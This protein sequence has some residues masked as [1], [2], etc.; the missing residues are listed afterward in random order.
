MEH[1]DEFGVDLFS[2]ERRPQKLRFSIL[3][4]NELTLPDSVVDNRPTLSNLLDR[5]RQPNRSTHKSK[6]Q[7]EI[8]NLTTK[9]SEIADFLNN[10]NDNIDVIKLIIDL[11]EKLSTDV[12][13][14]L[15]HRFGILSNEYVTLWKDCIK[16]LQDLLLSVLPAEMFYIRDKFDA[17]KRERQARAFLKK[18]ITDE[19]RYKFL[20]ECKSKFDAIPSIDLVTEGREKP[21]EVKQQLVVVANDLCEILKRRQL[22]P[23]I[24]SDETRSFHGQVLYALRACEN[25]YR[26]LSEI[27]NQAATK[28]GILTDFKSFRS[29]FFITNDAHYTSSRLGSELIIRA[30]LIHF[31]DPK[32]DILQYLKEN[33]SVLKVTS[34]LQQLFKEHIIDQIW[35]EISTT[36]IFELSMQND[37][38]QECNAFQKVVHTWLG[39]KLPLYLSETNEEST[40]AE[41]FR[42]VAEDISV[43]LVLLFGFLMHISRALRT[44]EDTAFFDFYNL[45]ATITTLK[46]FD[47]LFNEAI[48]LLEVQLEFIAGIN[49]KISRD[50]TGEIFENRT[51]PTRRGIPYAFLIEKTRGTRLVKYR[52]E[53][54]FSTQYKESC[55]RSCGQLFEAVKPVVTFL[56]QQYRLVHELLG[57]LENL[58][59]LPPISPTQSSYSQFNGR[60]FFGDSN[61]F[62]DI[63]GARD[64]NSTQHQM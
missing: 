9:L 43:E 47:T 49:N 42:F 2:E 18:W 30:Y 35:I 27:E 20:S 36:L 24:Y 37:T 52:R 23:G 5:L 21:A 60:T 25:Y 34:I 12:R 31:D 48:S 61:G 64:S 41:P 46:Q 45:A 53:V 8:D 59:H 62:H 13:N 55:Y 7:L 11:C 40:F 6:Q 54:I 39:H 50:I 26:R 51:L 38:S 57:N 4:E 28:T 58:A 44:S 17:Y 33:Y 10:P 22:E 32:V 63:G 3:E 56:K 14:G 19:G 16:T 15:V 29:L 1:E